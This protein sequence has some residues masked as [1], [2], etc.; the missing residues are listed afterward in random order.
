MKIL[1]CHNYYQRPG[2]E[3][4]VFHDERSL[5]EENG[6]D[7]I[8]YTKHNNS[9]VQLST[10]RV[11]RDTFWSRTSYRELSDV[12]RRERPDVMHCTNIFPLI[13]PAAYYA[14]R[15][16]RIPV[17]QSLHNFRL[18]CAN[19]Y[20]L[21]DGKVC[22]DCLG[23]TVAWPAIRHGCYRDSRGASA[24]VAGMQTFHR[25][26]GTWR[27]A[28]DRFISCS[29]FARQKLIESGLPGDRITVKPNFVQP[30]SGAGAGDSGYAVFV[31]RLSP[32]KGIETLL[33][34]WSRLPDPIPLK[35]IGDGPLV[36]RVTAAVKADPRIQ[37][38]G[39]QPLEQVLSLV[40][41]ASFLLMT[42]VWYETFGRTI[43]EAF[44][45]GTPVIVSQLGAMAELVDDGRTGLLFDPGNPND[46]VLRVRRLW[47]DPA[48]R[49]RMREQCRAEYEQKYTAA[50]N[51][52][53]LIDIYEGVLGRTI[54]APD[55]ILERV[56]ANA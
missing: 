38:L 37:W 49:E 25:L 7:V 23:K 31:G 34:G 6:H 19:G 28:V 33:E 55:S 9:I 36:D 13:S 14:A 27:N 45:K 30:D 46:L 21:R 48:G 22:E 5:L 43:I 47:H 42:S 40:G 17:I 15:S 18:H 32:E 41:R 50:A 54:E 8:V 10:T 35:I 11:V 26:L 44:S 16:Q 4:Q 51:Y 29:D 52:R 39:W 53:Q 3:D 56:P 1:L 24:V 20:F 12:I 2:G